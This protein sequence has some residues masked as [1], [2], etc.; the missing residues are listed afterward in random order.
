LPSPSTTAAA[1]EIIRELLQASFQ[2]SIDS[3]S[4][5]L[6]AAA[7]ENIDSR[8]VKTHE[9]PHAHSAC[10]KYLYPVLCQV[11]DRGH[12]SALL[13]RYVRQSSYILDLSVRDFHEGVEI[14]VSEVSAKK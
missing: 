12:A 5:R 8:L 9:R 2:E 7:V 1:C 3:L 11:I 13:V 10:D 14:A 4:D 6:D